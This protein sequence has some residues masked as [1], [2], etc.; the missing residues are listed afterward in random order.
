MIQLSISECLTKGAVITMEDFL[1]GTLGRLL[2][3]IFSALS[4]I[5]IFA[6]IGS[7]SV[8]G[9]GQTIGGWILFILGIVFGCAVFG[10]RYWLGHII[11]PR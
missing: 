6:G 4:V 5:L 2:Q 3:I 8:G 9:T 7:C 10:I 11:R 1:K